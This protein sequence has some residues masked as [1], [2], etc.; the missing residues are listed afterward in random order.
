MPPEIQAALAHLASQQQ[1]LSAAAQHVASP[2]Q[3]M[4]DHMTH[5]V[6]GLGNQ[7]ILHALARSRVTAQ[8]MKH[9]RR[10]RPHGG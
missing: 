9:L 10:I 3:G 6:A 2:G 7:E 8:V 1:S 4:H 5:N